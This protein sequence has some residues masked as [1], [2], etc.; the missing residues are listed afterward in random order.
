MSGKMTIRMDKILR[1]W[2]EAEAGIEAVPTGSDARNKKLIRFA[3]QDFENRG[4]ARRRLDRKGRTVW[5]ATP[6]MREYLRDAELDCR[7]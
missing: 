1:I 3:L 4:F 7:D 2:V 6:R 5:Q